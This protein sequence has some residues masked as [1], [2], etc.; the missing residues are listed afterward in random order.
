MLTIKP[1]AVATAVRETAKP[2]LD[3]FKDH[4]I[5]G[6]ESMTDRL[7]AAI[8][9][10]LDGK[11]IGNV[12]WKARTL[13]TARGKG[14]E[15]KRHGADVLGVLNIDVPGY[16]TTKG[17]LWQAK[18]V[19]PRHPIS[20]HEW[21]RFQNQCKTMLDRTD[22]AFAVIYSRKKGVRFIPA[23]VVLAIDRFSIYDVGAR[24]LYGF[25]KSHVKCEIGDQK[26]N[27]PTIET[28]DRIARESDDARILAMRATA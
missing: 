10:A 1:G 28:L 7:V 6:E 18:I 21:K 26:L 14:A 27:R 2:I 3:D 22:E 20:E 13:K 17:F 11:H 16:K 24:T 9:I 23:S 19:E 15:E 5:S 25:F 4:T 8:R 12:T